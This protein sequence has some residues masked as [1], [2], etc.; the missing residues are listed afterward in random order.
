VSAGDVRPSR[1]AKKERKRSLLWLTEAQAALSWGILLTMAALV[2]AI[3]L[4]QTTG[5]ATAGYEGESTAAFLDKIRQ[6]GA[7]VVGG[8]CGTNHHHITAIAKTY[9][10]MQKVK[11]KI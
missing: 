6:S 11:L 10:N 8:C 7:T 5:I 9:M 3:Y 4:F 1:K 2:G